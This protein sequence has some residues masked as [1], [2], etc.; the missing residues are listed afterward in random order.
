[1]IDMMKNGIGRDKN[2]SS[3][4]VLMIIN[5]ES[6]EACERETIK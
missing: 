3:I 6:G 4:N 5:T 2:Q 1:M